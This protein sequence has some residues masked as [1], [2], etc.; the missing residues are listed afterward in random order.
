MDWIPL[1]AQIWPIFFLSMRL[2]QGNSSTWL[3]PPFLLQNTK[4]PENQSNALKIHQEGGTGKDLG[5]PEDFGKKKKDIFASVVDRV[6]QRSLSYT[7]RFL[8]T[9]R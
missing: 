6:R 8:L 9:S 4:S 7:N 3:S 5:L 2:F 1:A